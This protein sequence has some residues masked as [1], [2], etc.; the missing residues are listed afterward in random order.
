MEEREAIR[1][2]G[3]ESL[4]KGQEE[5]VKTLIS[6]K[7]CYCVLPTGFGKSAIFI[8]PPLVNNWTN[9]I[10]TPLVALM[11]DHYLNLINH[12]LSARLISSEQSKKENEAALEAYSANEAQFLFVAPE[13]V[14]DDR[15]REVIKAKPPDMVTID[16]AHVASE[17][18]LSFRPSYCKIAPYVKLAK[19]TLVLTATSPREVERDIFEIFDLP[20]DTKRIIYLPRREN[21]K[22]SSLIWTGDLGLA[23]RFQ[24]SGI[25]YC[26]TIREVERLYDCFK[27]SI[28]GGC[29]IYH[30]Q[31]KGRSL[32]QQDWMTGEKRVMIC[33]NAFGLG[34]NKL[35]TRFVIVRDVPA[36]LE[37]L[38]QL[39]G[40]AGRDGLEANCVMY[41]DQQSIKTQ[42]FLISCRYPG[43]AE[44]IAA[45]NVIKKN[46]ELTYLEIA[47][48]AGINKY[49]IRAVMSI[50]QSF[51]VVSDKKVTGNIKDV[52]FRL[53]RKKRRL[54]EKK[55]KKVLGF[56]HAKDKVK[57]LEKHISPE[58]TQLETG[59]VL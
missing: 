17:H 30:G 29:T 14:L 3:F 44:I 56:H 1:R 26:S 41:Y 16:E 27:D 37:E 36:T 54:A 19:V 23:N 28:S 32:N 42:E 48:R 50:L 55:F 49:S 21:L 10:F 57:Y 51:N 31:L 7:S 38:A 40:R 5:A 59:T 34:I 24:G 11:R 47:K 15:F 2:L 4:R 12:G 45:Y 53:L 35:D 22:L 13:R 18:A 39:F 25:V 58:G 52:D 6:G 33:T 20:A 46:P 9:L 8:I 43:P